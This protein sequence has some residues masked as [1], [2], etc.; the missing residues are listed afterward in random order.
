MKKLKKRNNKSVSKFQQGGTPTYRKVIYLEKDPGEV[1]SPHA[2]LK[3]WTPGLTPE[4]RMDE[5]VQTLTSQVN[6]LTGTVINNTYQ[7]TTEQQNLKMIPL[8][9]EER[10]AYDAVTSLITLPIGAGGFNLLAN[11]V[12][13]GLQFIPKVGPVLSR[14]PRTVTT[15]ASAGLGFG[16]GYA[17]NKDEIGEYLSN[18]DDDITDE[19]FQNM[20]GEEAI[21]DML[22]W[23]GEHGYKITKSGNVKNPAEIKRSYFIHPNEKYVVG[24]QG[25]FYYE[26]IPFGLGLAV[27]GL[28]SKSWFPWAVGG[29]YVLGK[30]ARIFYNNSSA[31]KAGKLV[32]Y[33][34]SKGYVTIRNNQP[35]YNVQTNQVGNPQLID[36]VS[37]D[38]IQ[39]SAATTVPYNE[40]QTGS[41]QDS[42]NQDYYGWEND[43]AQ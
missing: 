15:L 8:S 2:D 40:G 26:D 7:P 38:Q 12:G 4:E 32:N 11:G 10:A 14:Y 41:E 1:E 17:L 30:A 43:T 27:K 36:T 6:P 39:D 21:P 9:D 3:F 19:D 29:S 22:Q 33:L 24:P 42:I 34:L 35:S 28:R 23:L 5:T 20:G 25:A 18:I 13:K 16:T 37:N 31:A